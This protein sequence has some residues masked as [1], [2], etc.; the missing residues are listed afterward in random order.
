MLMSV[1][2]TVKPPLMA[3]SG[4][5]VAIISFRGRAIYQYTLSR[6]SGIPHF[7]GCFG[8]AFLVLACEELG[9]PAR[10]WA[11]LHTGEL[12]AWVTESGT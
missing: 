6:D 12:T 11:R 1:G 3:L 10:K 7:R 5:S 2:H 8:L 9:A 4:S